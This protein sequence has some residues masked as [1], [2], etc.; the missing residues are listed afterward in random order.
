MHET[1]VKMHDNENEDCS[2]HDQSRAIAHGKGIILKESYEKMSGEFFSAF[3]R[4]RFNITFAKAGPK[5][6]GARLSV[7]DNDPCVKPVRKL[8]RHYVILRL[9]FTVY[10]LA[11][12]T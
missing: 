11:L 7:M 3:I 12:R 1:V 5:H 10:H 9:S 4:S 8:W 2:L 6:N